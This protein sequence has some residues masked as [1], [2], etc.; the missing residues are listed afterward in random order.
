[1]N[2]LELPRFLS[3][4][5]D[6]TNRYRG[7]ILDLWGVVHNGE[8][9]LPGAIPAL[10]ALRLAGLKICFLSNSPR[11]IPDVVTRLERMGIGPLLYDH[12]V[13]SGEAVFEALT[14]PMDSWHA[15]LGQRY[16]H[17]GPPDLAGLLSGTKKIRVHTAE[18]ADFILNTGFDSSQGSAALISQLK[19]CASRRLPMICANPD[20]DV[21]IG[22]TLV[23][24]AG[25]IASWYEQLDGHVH[26]HG[27]PYGPIY[28]CALELLGLSQSAVLAIG[29]SLRTDVLGAQSAGLDVVLIASGVHKDELGLAIN[30]EIDRDRLQALL[31]S[32]LAQP[33]FVADLFMWDAPVFLER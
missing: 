13:T 26:Y 11:R 5:S 7:V 24:C 6:V 28:Q 19:L 31:Q 3:G 4:I 9:A 29:D 16:L 25:T 20:L 23:M 18:A 32:Y 17:V 2:K 27:K 14:D 15:A 10:E 1:M 22:D 12:V 30:G 8:V 21:H 33:T